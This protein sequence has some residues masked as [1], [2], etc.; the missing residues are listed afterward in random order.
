MKLAPIIFRLDI[1]LYFKFA[2][3]L[4]FR[5]FFYVCAITSKNSVFT[6]LVYYCGRHWTGS[7]KSQFKL[8]GMFTTCFINRNILRVMI[9]KACLWKAVDYFW[10]L[11]SFVTHDSWSTQNH[12]FY[13]ALSSVRELPIGCFYAWCS[14]ITL[15]SKTL[16]LFRFL[17]MIL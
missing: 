11:P 12:T 1:L 14:R 8:Y 17:S 2:H 3:K 15:P 16:I 10:E 7:C 5:S 4:T 6:I 9:P 13:K